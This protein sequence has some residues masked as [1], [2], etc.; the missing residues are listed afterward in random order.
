MGFRGLLKP[1][2]VFWDCFWVSCRLFV[3]CFVLFECLAYKNTASQLLTELG[4]VREHGEG[5]LSF[6]RGSACS[7]GSVLTSGL[8]YLVTVYRSNCYF[9]K[10]R[11]AG[12]F[13]IRI[14]FY[15]L[16]CFFFISVVFSL[17]L[18]EIMLSYSFLQTVHLS[19]Q[20]VSASVQQ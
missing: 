8:V 5:W 10:Q 18:L 9:H 14:S 19:S 7:R 11:F 1:L 12:Y 17:S 4:G 2:C 20:A 3:V 6:T 15:F 13:A 16:D